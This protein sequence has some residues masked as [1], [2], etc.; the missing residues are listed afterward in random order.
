VLFQGGILKD[1]PVNKSVKSPSITGEIDL[2][3]KHE[4]ISNVVIG[5]DEEHETKNL[6]DDHF[7]QVC[8]DRSEPDPRPILREERNVNE[9]D[10]AALT[11]LTNSPLAGYD[12]SR[13]NP[14]PLLVCLSV[15]LF[16]FP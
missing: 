5:V 7:N 11:G 9:R 10:R 3:L 2:D 4:A 12:Y 15:L 14:L 16:F 13:N 8:E 1:F 6:R